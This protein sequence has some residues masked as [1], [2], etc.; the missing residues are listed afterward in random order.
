MKK[1][2]SVVS[3][4][5]GGNPTK[6]ISLPLFLYF[7]LSLS[8]PFSAPPFSLAHL[9]ALFLF[10]ASR[11]MCIPPGE[12]TEIRND[13]F[14]L[15]CE[16]KKCICLPGHLFLPVN[17]RRGL[18]NVNPADYARAKGYNNNRSRPGR[19]SPRWLRTLLLSSL[20]LMPANLLNFISWD[21]AAHIPN[22]PI[23]RVGSGDPGASPF[24][25]RCNLI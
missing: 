20:L 14:I 16:E 2:W 11:G 6:Y 17:Q 5:S 13:V 22:S 19:I 23:P 8:L 24:Y 15:I 9:F 3:E 10:F 25:A 18:T 21:P 1:T 12:L 4:S 7:F